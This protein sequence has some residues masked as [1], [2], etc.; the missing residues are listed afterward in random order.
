MNCWSRPKAFPLRRCGLIDFLAG[1]GALTKDDSHAKP[2]RREEV[3]KNGEA[4]PSSDAAE[5][6]MVM[7]R[8]SLTAKR[9]I[10]ASLRLC[11]K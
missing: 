4:A 6:A 9:Y 7:R 1:A 3:T 11:V 8:A 10:F 2:Q 5:T